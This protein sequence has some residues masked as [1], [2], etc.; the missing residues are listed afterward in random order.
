VIFTI[1]GFGGGNNYQFYMAL[2]GASE[3]QFMFL[4]V[5][6][7]G[8]KT[9]RH[10]DFASAVADANAIEVDTLE[11]EDSDANCCPSRKS[12]ARYVFSGGRLSETNRS[13]QRDV[14]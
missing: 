5:I 14:K 8:E 2:F 10:V 1:E 12:K 13:P 11:Y 7:I 4:D 3:D 6:K 9:W